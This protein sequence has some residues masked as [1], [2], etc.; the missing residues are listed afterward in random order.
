MI[1]LT[2]AS[3]SALLELHGDILVEL[4]R[5][6][7]VR[8]ANNPASEYGE[9]LFSRAFP[10]VPERLRPADVLKRFGTVPPRETTN[11]SPRRRRP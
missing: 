2:T 9:L 11:P 5:R 4:R 3:T 8:S 10:A 7:I 6:A 1:D